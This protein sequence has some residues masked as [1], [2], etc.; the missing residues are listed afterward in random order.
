[1]IMLKNLSKTFGLIVGA[2][3]LL[4]SLIVRISKCPT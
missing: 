2:P 4:A 1:M 3:L